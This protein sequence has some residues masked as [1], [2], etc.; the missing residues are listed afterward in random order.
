MGTRTLQ[1]GNTGPWQKFLRTALGTLTTG[2]DHLSLIELLSG[3]AGFWGMRLLVWKGR[4]NSTFKFKSVD[5][6]Q[7]VGEGRDCPVWGERR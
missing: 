6:A 1:H 7:G 3:E 4:R 5:R 2:R